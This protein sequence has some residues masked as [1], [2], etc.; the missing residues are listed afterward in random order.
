MNTLNKIGGLLLAAVLLVAVVSGLNGTDDAVP[1]KRSGQGVLAGLWDGVRGSV[2]GIG[3]SAHLSGNAVGSVG[4]AALAALGVL[5]LVPASRGG[6]AFGVTLVLGA[7][8]AVV[9]YDP[10]LLS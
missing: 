3:S 4:V 10:A 9:L 2:S 8:L 7:L 1:I 6:R 5:L